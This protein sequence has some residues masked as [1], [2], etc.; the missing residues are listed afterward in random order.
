MI[1]S[2]IGRISFAFGSVVVILPCLS[3]S[4]TRLRNIAVRCPV[5][6]SNLR[7]LTWCLISVS[8]APPALLLLVVSFTATQEV[9]GAGPGVVTL[10]PQC[11]HERRAKRSELFLVLV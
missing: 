6:L 5:F 9:H 1:F 11:F 2:A 3:K 4:V 7:P 8:A 10:A